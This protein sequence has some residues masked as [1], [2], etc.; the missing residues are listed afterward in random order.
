MWL[1]QEKK[2]LKATALQTEWRSSSQSIFFNK[3]L[4][5]R[6]DK[7]K[8]EKWQQKNKT[9]AKP[10]D[11][12]SLCYRL[13][14]NHRCSWRPQSSSQSGM[15]WKI[16]GRTTVFMIASVL[17]LQPQPNT[18]VWHVRISWQKRWVL[19]GTISNETQGFG[20]MINSIF[21]TKDTH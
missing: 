21:Q 6:Q 20:H 13:W 17:T 10:L 4:N 12:W 18:F 5:K 9:A 11:L 16:P 7:I 2:H 14:E 1:V 3:L 19:I 8:K 15:P